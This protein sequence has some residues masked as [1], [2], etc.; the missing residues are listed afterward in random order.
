MPYLTL[1]NAAV[2]S[3]SVT[4][5]LQGRLTAD[6]LIDAATAPDVGTAVTLSFEGGQDYRCTVE[7]SGQQGGFYSARVVGGTGGLS[8]PI[9]ARYYRDIPAAQVVR[10]LLGEC[11]ET[12]GEID[13]P[14]KLSSWVRPAGPAHE[15]LR[16]LLM[17][18]P[19]RYWHMEPDGRVNVGVP[20]WEAHARPLEIE[21]EHPPRGAF[22][23]A[24]D[25]SLTPG[26]RA[27][28]TRGE[29][30]VTKRITRVTHLIAAWELR[31]ELGTGDGTD[32]GIDGLGVIVAQQLRYLDYTGLYPAKILKDWGDHTLDIRPENPL[33]PEMT[34]VRLVQPLPGTRVK[35]KAGGTVLLG[36]QQADPARPAVLDYAQAELELLEVLTGQG[37]LITLDDDRGQTSEDERYSAPRIR[38]QDRAGQVLELFAERGH[39]RVTLTDKA[40][41]RLEML[42]ELNQE[43]VTLTDKAGQ[44]LELSAVDGQERVTLTDKAGQRLEMNAQ[45][46]Q[47]KITLTDK[48]GQTLRLE[49][50]NQQIFLTHS[51]GSTLTMSSG[52]DVVVNA[53]GLLRLGG[54]GPGVARIGDSVSTP[55]G[56]GII[57]GG[58]SRVVCG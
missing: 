17:R 54:G 37:Q 43:K 45:A 57:T 21:T 9:S 11:G 34:H 16:A 58:S 7:R 10:D 6:V 4:L 18:Y 52:G 2:I 33:L 29:K 15:L 41:Q 26:T 56:P 8:K 12:A 13:L 14:G 55:S 50:V 44:R 27:T 1:N 35:L 36:F 32:L 3:G 28:L 5:P 49:A 20:R 46:G 48:A 19:E 39:E 40:G 23:V 31:T 25:A 30:S 42:A 53:T 38:L 47:E 51:S 22:T 24:A